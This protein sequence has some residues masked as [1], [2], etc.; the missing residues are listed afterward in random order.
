MYNS[1][2]LIKAIGEI[3]EDKVERTSY[4]LGYMKDGRKQ[5]VPRVR[6]RKLLVLAAVF[7]MLLALGAGAYAV[8]FGGIGEL[9]PKTGQ[10]QPTFPPEAAKEIESR[11]EAAQTEDWTC[12]I[13]ETYCDDTKLII[14]ANVSCSDRYIPVA[15]DAMEEEPAANHGFDYQGTLA[16]YAAAQGKQLLM[17]N[18]GVNDEKVGI[19][20]ASLLFEN[21]SD[22]ELLI[23]YSGEKREVFDEIETS[24]AVIAYVPGAAE[25]E[26]IELPL[27][28]QA[29]SAKELGVYAPLDPDAVPGIHAG[30]AALTETPFGLSIQYPVQ[31]TDE[32]AYCDVMFFNGVEVDFQGQGALGFTAEDN[33]GYARLTA[34]EGQVG[35]TLTIRYYDWDKQ[36][37]GDL[38]FQRK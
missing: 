11:E 26:R 21:V 4:A 3:D 20:S 13:V 24:C 32:E 12:R 22:H 15:T 37:V 6:A 29:G 5:T 16:E 28:L 31:I 17:M 14:T 36:P 33:T 34:G 27:A 7:A 19:I 10:D 18:L 9:W 2:R 30:E 25:P 38:V 23:L 35:D 1:E 8:A